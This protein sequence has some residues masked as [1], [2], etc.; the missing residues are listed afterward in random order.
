M[1][2]GS[3]CQESAR[4]LGCF[5]MYPVRAQVWAKGLGLGL[6]LFLHV[7]CTSTG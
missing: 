5:F 3:S 1:A 4:I 6:G 7:T 2:G